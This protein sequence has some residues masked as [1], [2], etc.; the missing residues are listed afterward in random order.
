MTKLNCS[1][2]LSAEIS[3]G[4]MTCLRERKWVMERMWKEEQ[5]PTFWEE[6]MLALRVSSSVLLVTRSAWSTWSCSAWVFSYTQTNRAMRHECKDTS[7]HAGILGSCECIQTC[8][9]AQPFGRL[10]PELPS[11]APPFLSSQSPP[12]PGLP[13][14]PSFAESLLHS[15]TR[16]QAASITRTLKYWMFWFV[17]F[18]K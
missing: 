5:D 7:R 16:T 17:H 8:I 4:V 3:A 15:K 1:Q 6:A 18:F 9:Y 2:K 11:V 12:H 14:R 13:E 10:P